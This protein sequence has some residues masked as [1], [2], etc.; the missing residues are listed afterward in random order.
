MKESPC[1]GCTVKNCTSFCESW[2]KWFRKE[3]HRVQ[4]LF[5]KEKE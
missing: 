3:W 2:K 1:K 4:K 5:Q